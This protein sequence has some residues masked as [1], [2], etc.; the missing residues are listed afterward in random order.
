[1]DKQRQDI[2]LILPSSISAVFQAERGYAN[3]S[4]PGSVCLFVRSFVRLFVCRRRRRLNADWLA[5]L[6]IT[7]FARGDHVWAKYTS[8]QMT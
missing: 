6:L 4:G 2:Y 3:Y 1:M 7:L 8:G 5:P